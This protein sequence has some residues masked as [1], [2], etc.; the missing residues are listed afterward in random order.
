MKTRFPTHIAGCLCTTQA[1]S[2]AQGLYPDPASLA[3]S[4]AALAFRIVAE[5]PQNSWL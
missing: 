2:V 3:G 1:R 5:F 4:P